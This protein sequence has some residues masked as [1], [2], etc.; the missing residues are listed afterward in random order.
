MNES[1][2]MVLTLAAIAGA[3]VVLVVLLFLDGRTLGA[4]GDELDALDKE[5]ASLQSKM[6]GRPALRSLVLTASAPFRRYAAM[7]PDDVGMAAMLRIVHDV[8][9]AARRGDLAELPGPLLAFEGSWAEVKESKSRRGRSTT[10]EEERPTRSYV[11]TI[12]ISGS[13]PAVVRFIEGMERA[14]ERPEGGRLARLVSIERAGGRP[15]AGVPPDPDGL[16]FGVKFE[17]PTVRKPVRM[18]DLPQD[19]REA[20]DRRAAAA[21]GLTWRVLTRPF[22]ARHRDVTIRSRGRRSPF[23]IPEVE[24]PEVLDV[25]AAADSAL[26]TAE[27]EARM[28]N[29]L[30]GRYA[31][32][33]ERFASA[34]YEEVRTGTAGMADQVDLLRFPSEAGRREARRWV[35][36][37]RALLARAEA[38]EAFARLPLAVTFIAWGADGRSVAILNGRSFLPGTE[39]PAGIRVDSVRE[40]SVVVSFRGETFDLPLGWRQGEMPEGTQQ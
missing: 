32:L 34:A 33:E 40:R 14:G 7:V 19:V 18:R 5:T 6:K 21:V 11:K 12:W 38:R 20:I 1:R 39:T 9:R 37:A 23:A 17:I 10:K 15:V 31:V 36:Q 28:L 8:E 26:Y 4:L 27:E 16:S 30:A 25:P 24:I 35:E 2:R 13:F 29:D 3:V 22:R